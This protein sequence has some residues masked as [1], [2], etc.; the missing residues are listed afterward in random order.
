MMTVGWAARTAR[1]SIDSLPIDRKYSSP[2]RS[3]AYRSG[4]GEGSEF[5]LFVDVLRLV[6]HGFLKK[7]DLALLVLAHA[8]HGLADRLDDRGARFFRK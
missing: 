4:G 7:P 2:C 6:F 8:V 5:L 3:A 1:T